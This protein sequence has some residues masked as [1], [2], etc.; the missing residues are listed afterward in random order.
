MVNYNPEVIWEGTVTAIECE[1]G[2]STDSNEGRMDLAATVLARTNKGCRG[3]DTM[4]F[5][6][7]VG[8]VVASII[9]SGVCAGSRGPSSGSG[10]EA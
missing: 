7:V 5:V 2:S 6:Q 8:W 3:Y 10:P 9:G 4:L 1:G